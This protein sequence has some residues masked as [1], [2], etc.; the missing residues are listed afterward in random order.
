MFTPLVTTLAAVAALAT[1]APARAQEVHLIAS[2]P[3]EFTVGNSELPRDTYRISRLTAHPEMLLVRGDR[4]SAFVR[5][6]PV[7]VPRDDASPSLLFHRYGDQYF[8]REIRW[9][10][11][12][13]LDLPETKA[14]R[15]MAERRA[16]RVAAK[17]ETVVIAAER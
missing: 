5:T 15:A 14:E 11:N 8:L 12:S 3:F 1:A 2:V 16:D 13:R 17:M 9:E 7:A 4:H 10:G 6:D